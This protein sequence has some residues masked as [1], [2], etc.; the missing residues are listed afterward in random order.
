MWALR[1]LEISLENHPD[2]CQG[3]VKFG[4]KQERRR[5]RLVISDTNI[6]IDK[7]NRIV[8]LSFNLPAGCFATT[9][10]RELLTYQDL[11]ARM[12]TDK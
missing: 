5:I 9:V 2:F 3:L 4:L 7:E 10:L 1:L 8:K 6:E 11:T 12:V